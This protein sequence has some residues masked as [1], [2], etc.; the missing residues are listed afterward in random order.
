MNNNVSHCKMIEDMLNEVRREVKIECA[1][2]VIRNINLSN[3]EISEVTGLTLEEVKELKA[4][5]SE[6]TE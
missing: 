3:E 5:A 2:R 1:L 4:Y 6:V